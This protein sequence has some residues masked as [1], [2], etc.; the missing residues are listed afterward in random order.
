M[1]PPGTREISRLGVEMLHA[2]RGL[3][4]SKTLSCCFSGE[5]VKAGL[6]GM[7]TSIKSL[8]AVGMSGNGRLSATKVL[9]VVLSL[10][11]YALFFATSSF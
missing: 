2:N 8:L 1:Q 7:E 11:I 10:D 4:G 9:P 3:I 5:L 6:G